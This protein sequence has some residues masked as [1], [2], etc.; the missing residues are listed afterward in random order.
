[1]AISEEQLK[2]EV[3]FQTAPAVTAI[4]FYARRL[5]DLNDPI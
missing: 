5:E 3:L 4:I 1:M 2:L